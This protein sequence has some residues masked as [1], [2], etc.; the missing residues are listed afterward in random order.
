MIQLDRAN[1]YSLLTMGMFMLTATLSMTAFL[2]S[3]FSII[4]SVMGLNLFTI[5]LL[6]VFIIILAPIW[7]T[8]IRNAAKAFEDSKKV[9]IQLEEMLFKLYPEY[10]NRLH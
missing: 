9:N 6:I 8:N 3:I 2:A 4:Y 1:R 5:V 7:Y 10:K